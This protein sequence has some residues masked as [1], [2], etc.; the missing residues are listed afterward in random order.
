LMWPPSSWSAWFG[1]HVHVI[2]FLYDDER[3]RRFAAVLM[4][5]A[6]AQGADIG[7]ETGLGP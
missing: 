2:S 3:A 7:N 5:V 4:S 6:L 1:I